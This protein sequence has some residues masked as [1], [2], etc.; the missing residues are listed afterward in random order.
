M[1][2]VGGINTHTLHFTSDLLLAEPNQKLK[3][4][5][6]PW[7]RCY[8]PASQDTEQ[9]R[10]G[11]WRG[12]RRPFST[13]VFSVFSSLAQRRSARTLTLPMKKMRCREIN[14]P[15]T[16]M[17]VTG[18][19]SHTSA[20]E[21]ELELLTTTRTAQ[22]LSVKYRK[23]ASPRATPNSYWIKI[24]WGVLEYVFYKVLQMALMYTM[25]KKQWLLLHISS[26]V[27][28]WAFYIICKLW[29]KY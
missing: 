27:T 16:T 25:V 7:W 28:L 20:S 10:A 3:G 18:V 9:G 26:K 29:V 19:K 2:C 6:A 24:S 14:L 17:P 15:T 23:I 21:S 4:K 22:Q 8:K 13:H 5:G 1:G 11:I 12:N